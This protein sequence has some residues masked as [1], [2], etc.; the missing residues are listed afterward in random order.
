M[1]ICLDDSLDVSACRDV[2]RLVYGHDRVLRRFVVASVERRSSLVVAGARLE[3]VHGLHVRHVA[4]DGL[5]NLCAMASETSSRFF[6][7]GSSRPVVV[8]VT[9][10]VEAGGNVATSMGGN[11]MGANSWVVSSTRMGKALAST[12]VGKALVSTHL[13]KALASTHLGTRVNVCCVLSS[14]HLSCRI[15]LRE[16][17]KLLSV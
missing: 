9:D 7:D 13:G 16:K 15:N 12:L 10:V 11:S 2:H 14:S 1:V 6:S 5:G 3:G 8:V 4:E 17:T